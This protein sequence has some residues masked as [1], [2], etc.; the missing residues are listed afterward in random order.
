MGQ[1]ARDYLAQAVNPTLLKG[2]TELCKQKPQQPVVSVFLTSGHRICT[3]NGRI[4][5]AIDVALGQ[6]QVNIIL[7]STFIMGLVA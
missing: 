5:S 1:A 7:L 6:L 2:L 4:S 3:S